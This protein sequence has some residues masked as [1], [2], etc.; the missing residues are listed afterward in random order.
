M[1]FAR[2]GPQRIGGD[3]GG[4]AQIAGVRARVRIGGYRPGRV[5]LLA[6]PPG[7]VVQVGG[8]RGGARRSAGQQVVVETGRRVARVVGEGGRHRRR[9]GHHAQ[10]GGLAAGPRGAATARVGEGGGQGAVGVEHRREPAGA[11]DGQHQLAARS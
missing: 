8:R 7:R 2:P 11:V 3:G 4:A 6:D 10:V 9:V 1:R 5:G